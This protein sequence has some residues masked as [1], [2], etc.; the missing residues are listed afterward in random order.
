MML[1]ARCSLIGLCCNQ[2]ETWGVQMV[3]AGEAIKGR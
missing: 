2:A 1:R 3:F